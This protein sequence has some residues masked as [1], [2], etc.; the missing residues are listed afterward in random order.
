M[1]WMTNKI[2][3]TFCCVCSSYCRIAYIA[4]FRQPIVSVT[5]KLRWCQFCGNGYW[6]ARWGL[7]VHTVCMWCILGHVTAAYSCIHVRSTVTNLCLIYYILVFA[8]IVHLKALY[9]GRVS[10]QVYVSCLLHAMQ[11]LH[12]NL[13]KSSH[14]HCW[15]AKQSR[16]LM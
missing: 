2:L 6:L 7:A 11:V 9:T 5:I 4:Y 15:K 8:A 12:I 10:V 16:L 14:L 3:Y 1:C 13:G